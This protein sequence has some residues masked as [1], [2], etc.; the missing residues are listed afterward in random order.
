MPPVTSV[1]ERVIKATSR[2]MGRTSVAAVQS[3]TFLGAFLLLIQPVVAQS[4]FE[5]AGEVACS[6]VLGQAVF[7]GFGLLTLILVL[8]GLGQ[9]AIGF[10][11]AGGGGRGRRG[12]RTNIVN[13]IVTLLGG[14]FLGSMG[15][16]LDYL[17]INLDSCLEGGEILAT[18]PFVF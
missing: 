4:A 1:A 11:G 5:E 8:V 14:L 2:V 15:A 16:V 9:V 7:L 10:L 12:E 13:G 6:G 17:G 3:V 18:M